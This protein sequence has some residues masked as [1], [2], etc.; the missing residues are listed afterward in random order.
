[1]SYDV[2]SSTC[3]RL[4]RFCALSKGTLAPLAGAAVSDA[5]Q[6]AAGWSR[7]RA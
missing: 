5:L 1:L 4:G 2:L 6:R 3:C 7:R